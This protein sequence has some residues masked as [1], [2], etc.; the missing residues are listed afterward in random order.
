MAASGGNLKQ[1]VIRLVDHHCA[2]KNNISK[3]FAS[4]TIIFSVLL[5]SSKQ[6]LTMPLLD[7]WYHEKSS[8]YSKNIT[9][10]EKV[11]PQI[12]K[13]RLNSALIQQYLPPPKR[14]R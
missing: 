14:I 1:R 13:V 2:P 9:Q 11:R 12:D 3:W 6:L 8:Q 4:A 7:I 10:V 5:L